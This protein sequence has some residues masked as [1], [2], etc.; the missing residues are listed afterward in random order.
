MTPDSVSGVVWTPALPLKLF[1]ALASLHSSQNVLY[2]YSCVNT[3]S[4]CDQSFVKSS[5]LSQLANGKVKRVS[6]MSWNLEDKGY[7]Q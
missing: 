6:V 3:A 5:V 1:M 7:H 4:K 2:T